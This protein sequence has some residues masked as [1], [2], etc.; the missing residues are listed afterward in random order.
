MAEKKI[1]NSLVILVWDEI[2][3]IKAL[4]PQIP[5]D[6]ADEVLFVDGGSTDGTIDFLKSQHQNVY[7][8]QLRGR[9]RAFLEGLNHT[10]GENIVFFSGDGNE[11]PKDIPKIF[12]ELNQGYEMVTAGRFLLPD[13]KSDDSDDPLLIRKYGN[14][15][16][17]WLAH[18]IWKTNVK[19]AING[20]RGFK[21]D[22]MTRMNL[23]A[24]KH[25]IEYQSTI[26]AAKLG[27][28]IR[29]IPTH[30]LERL[31]G[32]RKLTADTPTLAKNFFLFLIKEMLIGKKFIK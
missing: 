23:N 28:N 5:F 21:R 20:F 7:V 15:F 22:A 13:A 26:R 29:E 24:P 30:E 12:S 18:A 19:D 11:D 10:N 9:G 17:S 31:G 8:Q 3:A 25:E 4:Y 32:R 2:E 16:L 14:I 1:R 27:L 6:C